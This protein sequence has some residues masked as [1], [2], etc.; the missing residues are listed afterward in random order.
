MEELLV[1]MK[2]MMLFVPSTRQLSIIVKN[3]ES[4]MGQTLALINRKWKGL[5]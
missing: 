1:I 4:K 3:Q 5:A 2:M